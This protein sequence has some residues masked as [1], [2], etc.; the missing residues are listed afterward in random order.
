MHRE[1]DAM[2]IVVALTLSLLLATAV[3]AQ[4]GDGPRFTVQRFEIE[5]PLPI[6]REKV[7]C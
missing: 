6:P 2:R 5:G 4:S 3:H 7:D 1:L